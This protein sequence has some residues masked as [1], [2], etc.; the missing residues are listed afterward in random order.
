MAEKLLA[1]VAAFALGAGVTAIFAARALSTAMC[2]S[3][4]LRQEFRN[5]IT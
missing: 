1:L 4:K 3:P 2:Y 5:A